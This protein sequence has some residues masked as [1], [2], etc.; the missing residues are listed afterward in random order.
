MEHSTLLRT[1]ELFSRGRDLNLHGNG[2][3]RTNTGCCSSVGC[4]VGPAQEIVDESRHGKISLSGLQGPFSHG[5]L[6]NKRGFVTSV[7]LE[8]ETLNLEEN[9]GPTQPA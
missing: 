4:E 2:H 9:Q 5:P 6:R 7:W 3:A 1:A 8:I